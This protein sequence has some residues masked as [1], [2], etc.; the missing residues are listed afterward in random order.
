MV[1]AGV[2]PLTRLLGCHPPRG[3][4]FHH[5]GAAPGSRVDKLVE[6]A[7]YHMVPKTWSD[8]SRAP[9]TSWIGVCRSMHD[10]LGELGLHR[11]SEASFDLLIRGCEGAGRCAEHLLTGFTRRLYVVLNRRC[12]WIGLGAGLGG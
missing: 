2:D 4:G 9:A 10:L 5:H 3:P 11:L 6:N 12:G 1:P 8:T 7:G